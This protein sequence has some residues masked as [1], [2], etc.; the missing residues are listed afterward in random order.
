MYFFAETNNVITFLTINQEYQGSFNNG[1]QFSRYVVERNY[2]VT[3]MD[4]DTWKSVSVSFTI[5]KI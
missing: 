4:S 1:E 2:I 3:I 5:I